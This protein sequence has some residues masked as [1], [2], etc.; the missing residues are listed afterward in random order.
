MR[1][2]RKKATAVIVDGVVHAI[3]E[4]RLHTPGSS[5]VSMGAWSD[6]PL[7]P[8]RRTRAERKADKAKAQESLSEPMVRFACEAFRASLWHKAPRTHAAV[9]CMSCLV[10]VSRMDF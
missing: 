4:V 6:Y 10:A 9:N 2:K 7:S 5:S 3:G 1:R 8:D